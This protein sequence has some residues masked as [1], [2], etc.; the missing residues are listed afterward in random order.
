M[1]KKEIGSY[2]VT[3]PEI[4]HGKLIFKG[5]RV[6]VSTVLTFLAMGDSIQDILRNWPQLKRE[7]VE[8]AINFASDLI[9]ESYPSQRVAV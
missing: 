5:T 9:T 8:E 7:Y 6:P 4:C 3:D 1:Q 2:L